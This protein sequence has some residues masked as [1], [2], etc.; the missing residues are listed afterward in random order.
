[1]WPDKIEDQGRYFS[2]FLQF[3]IMHPVGERDHLRLFSHC[4]VKIFL[5]SL[6]LTRAEIVNGYQAIM[7]LEQGDNTV[8]AAV[9]TEQSGDQNERRALTNLEVVV[10][11][12]LV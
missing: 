6:G 7:A 11:F 2:G 4:I 5:G 3:E 9:N 12:L 8:K 10:M 1:M